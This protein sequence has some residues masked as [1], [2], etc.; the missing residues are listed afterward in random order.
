MKTQRVNTASGTMLGLIGIVPLI[1][2]IKEYSLKHNF[3]ICMKLKQPSIRWLD[4]A[5]TYKLGVDWDASVILYLWHDGWK[6]QKG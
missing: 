6:P 5:K 2:D 3:I 4:I 1:M